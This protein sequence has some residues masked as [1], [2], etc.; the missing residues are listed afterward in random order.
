MILIILIS[1][2][3]VN[4]LVLSIMLVKVTVTIFFQVMVKLFLGQLLYLSHLNLLLHLSLKKEWLFN[5]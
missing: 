5:S 3:L 1:H 2:E 4:G